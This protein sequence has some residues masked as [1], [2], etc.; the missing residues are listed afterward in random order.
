VKKRRREYHLNEDIETL[1]LACLRAA[2]AN[3]Y[4]DQDLLWLPELFAAVLSNSLIQ[5][6]L[7]KMQTKSQH[8][9]LKRR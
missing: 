7:H 5:P 8:S 2:I 1:P 3:M 4:V 6:H 9:S